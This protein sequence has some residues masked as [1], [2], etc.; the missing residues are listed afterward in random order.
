MRP[1]LRSDSENN[2]ACDLYWIASAEAR[3]RG[4]LPRTVRSYFDLKD[5]KSRQD[6][7]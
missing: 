3:K 2:G 1:D 7:E 4:Y 6:L 5:L